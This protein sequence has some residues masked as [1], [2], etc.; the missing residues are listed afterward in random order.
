[1]VEIRHTMGKI[2]FE[3]GWYR[4]PVYFFDEPLRHQDIT[5]IKTWCVENF[6]GRFVLHTDAITYEFDIY[7]MAF[8]LRW[9]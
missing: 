3:H 5:E 8:K 1:M 2:A 6:D 9:N 7:L 4:Y